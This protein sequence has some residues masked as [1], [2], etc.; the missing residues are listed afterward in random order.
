MKKLTLCVMTFSLLLF[1]VP[2]HLNAAP[3]TNPIV[4]DSISMVETATVT[5]LTA[6]LD[7]IALIDRSK[8]RPAERR[9]LRKEV[10]SINRQL[11]AV[12]NGGIYISAGTLLLVI[13]LLIILL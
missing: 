6:R 11:K 10:R 12:T 8:M 3:E 9:E 1:S 13:I 5:A 4:A 2:T 7:E